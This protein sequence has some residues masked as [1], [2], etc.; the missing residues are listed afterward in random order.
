MKIDQLLETRVQ[1]ISNMIYT[2]LILFT[3][4]NCIDWIFVIYGHLP[5]YSFFWYPCLV[6][7][8]E[9]CEPS[10]K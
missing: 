3:Q 9:L 5:K 7:P 1:H 2:A 8:V 4:A 10:C 6:L